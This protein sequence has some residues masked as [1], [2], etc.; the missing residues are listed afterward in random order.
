MQNMISSR[1][2]R[3]F[4]LAGAALAGAL[5]PGA[6]AAQEAAARP[7]VDTAL[8]L[9]VDASGS[10]D[11]TE[12]ALQREGIAAAVT[13][14]DLLDVISYGQYGTIAIAYLEWGGPGTA[15]V[16]VSWMLVNDAE[17]ASGFA[18]AVL[19]APRSLQS[20]NAIGDAITSG[21]AMLEACPCLP[22]RRIIDVSGDNP[23]NRSIVSAAIARDRAVGAGIVINALAILQDGLLG[24][25]GKPWL[26]EAYEADV[27]G[28]PGAFVMTAQNRRD[29]ERA[30]LDKML[31]EI[32]GGEPVPSPPLQVADDGVGRPRLQ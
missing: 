30:L 7:P 25:S 12:F 23:D 17:T 21:Q 2:L 11:P 29:F 6:A 32:S 9:A 26:V 3:L 15:E 13:S 18:A 22:S 14:A 19:A 20:Y 1:R 24:P 16:M 31:L 28:G 4:V 27:I 5:T 10:I 8:V